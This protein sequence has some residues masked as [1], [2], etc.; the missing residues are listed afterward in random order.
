[1]GGNRLTDEETL[2]GRE[3]GLSYASFANRAALSDQ[4]A[5]AG[6]WIPLFRP[7]GRR[8]RRIA[9]LG[10]QSAGRRRRGRRGGRGGIDRSIRAIDPAGAGRCASRT[11]GRGTY[12]SEQP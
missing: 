2:E 7:G 1:M 10:S 4:R 11:R 3:D 12:R 5:S 9:W 6:R 8:A